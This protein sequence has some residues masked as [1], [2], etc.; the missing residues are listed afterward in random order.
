MRKTPHVGSGQLPDDDITRAHLEP[1][2]ML[3]LAAQ[4]GD[5]VQVEVRPEP[6]LP[7]MFK[8]YVRVNGVTVLRICKLERRPDV[9]VQL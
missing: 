5:R 4:P 8:F 7:G 6:A 2:E 3:D 9:V 1:R